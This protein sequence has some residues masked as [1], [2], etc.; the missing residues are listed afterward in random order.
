MP[1][2]FAKRLVVLPFAERHADGQ[3]TWDS[4]RL[5]AVLV[6]SV[7]FWRCPTPLRGCLGGD[8]VIFRG[9][10]QPGF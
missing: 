10:V 1:A 7:K 6:F 5:R 8:F 9:S 4:G 2:L 3:E